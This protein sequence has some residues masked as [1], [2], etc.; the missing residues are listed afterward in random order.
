MTWWKKFIWKIELTCTHSTDQFSQQENYEVKDE[1]M[2]A[3]QEVDEYHELEATSFHD[4]AK[5]LTDAE[6]VDK[7]RSL[8]LKQRQMFNFCYN[9]AKQQQQ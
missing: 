9:W 7:I 4:N 5:I 2:T 3:A 6:I 8:N 1:I